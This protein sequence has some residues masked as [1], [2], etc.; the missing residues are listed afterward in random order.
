METELPAIAILPVFFSPEQIL[1]ALAVLIPALVIFNLILISE[2]GLRVDRT[3]VLP[4]DA[5]DRRGA[6]REPDRYPASPGGGRISS[7]STWAG[8]VIPPSS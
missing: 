4:G 3:Q 2:G 6:A 8:A 5:G 7:R 1:V